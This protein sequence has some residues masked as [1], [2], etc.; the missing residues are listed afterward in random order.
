V[1]FYVGGRLAQQTGTW[2][3]FDINILNLT[4]V[5]PTA[6]PVATTPATTT[7]GTTTTPSATTPGGAPATA[8]PRPPSTGTG[9]EGGDSAAIWLFALIGAGALA[10]GTGGALVARRSR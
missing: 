2:R 10:F 6:T 4:V 7:P 3:N 8:T 1:T 9:T 5:T